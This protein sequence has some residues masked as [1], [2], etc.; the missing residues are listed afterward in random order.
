MGRRQV[1]RPQGG[2]VAHVEAGDPPLKGDGAYGAPGNDRGAG[3]VGDAIEFA[4][5][6]GQGHRAV[7]QRG[8][9]GG[10]DREQLATGETGEDKAVGDERAGRYA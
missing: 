6:L 7:P 3:D 9:V 4:A 10:T 5:A 2:A 8:A 1:T